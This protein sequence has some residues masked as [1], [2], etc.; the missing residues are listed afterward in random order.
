VNADDIAEFDKTTPI[1]VVATCENGTHVLRP[2][3]CRSK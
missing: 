3:G 2:V 1:T